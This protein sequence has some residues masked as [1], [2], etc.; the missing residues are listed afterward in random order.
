[1][2][3]NEQIQVVVRS[4]GSNIHKKD[5]FLFNSRKYCKVC[6]DKKRLEGKRLKGFRH[7]PTSIETKIELSK[8]AVKHRNERYD[9]FTSIDQISLIIGKRIIK[10]LNKGCSICGWNKGR[11]DYHHIKSKSDGG[12][13]SYSNITYICPNCHRLIHS[14]TLKESLISLDN[15]INIEEIKTFVKSKGKSKSIYKDE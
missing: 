6:G 5:L 7:K 14:G 1:M 2:D 10:R 4:D 3:C 13:N 12:K 11:G 9:S 8:A 15:Y